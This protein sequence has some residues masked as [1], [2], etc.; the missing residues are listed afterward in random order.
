MSVAPFST[1]ASS[2][3]FPACP[4]KTRIGWIGLGVMGRSMAAHLL[5]AG[6]EM[7]VHTR[8]KSTAETL[9]EQGATWC[10]SPSAVASDTHIVCVMVGFPD[11]VR[12]VVLGPQGVLNG[13]REG[14]IM[15]DHTTSSPALAS[16]IAEK[17]L[18]QNCVSL[19]APV[20]G[21]DIGARN[22]TLTIMVGGDTQAQNAVAPY[23]NILAKTVVACGGPGDGQKTK[24]TNQV[25]IAA[26]MVAMCE[27]LLF[28]SRAGLD[29]H[30][31]LQAISGGAAGSWSLSNLAPR[32]L[33]HDFDP[34][35]FVEHFVKDMRLALDECRRM[36]LILPGLELAS[37]LYDKLMQQGHGRLGT[38]A[39]MRVLA[40]MNNASLPMS[41]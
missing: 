23:W 41:S 4:G 3:E 24:L 1:I 21:G 35:F 7:F 22:G 37:T 5:N 6:Y 19:D 30:T 36:K 9:L 29:M 31:T 40:D 8:R 16:E 33:T 10:D 18:S 17:A 39:L 25:A 12:K 34:G 13:A 20:S 11:D 15:V 32:I 27:A 2:N 26:S 14:I 28:A 38:Q